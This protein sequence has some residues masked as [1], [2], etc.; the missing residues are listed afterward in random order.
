M[1]GASVYPLKDVLQPTAPAYA[2]N[3]PIQSTTSTSASYQCATT[4]HSITVGGVVATD[5]VQCSP[6]ASAVD[7]TLSSVMMSCY[8][9]AGKIV[10]VEFI[11]FTGTNPGPF[12]AQI[13]IWRT[14]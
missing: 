2:V 5:I 14:I 1:T 3:T 8:A 9:G 10:V 6:A 11:C 12:N 13:I 7:E 4:T